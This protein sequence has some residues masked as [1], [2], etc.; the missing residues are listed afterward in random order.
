MTEESPKR[1]TILLK[2]VPVCEEG[3]GRN[4]VGGRTA[5][6]TCLTLQELN[7]IY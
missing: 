5:Y 7:P 4:P 2:G 3:A 6:G 1:I